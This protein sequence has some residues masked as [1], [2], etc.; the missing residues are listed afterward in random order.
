MR[1]TVFWVTV[2]SSFQPSNRPTERARIGH[3]H[4]EIDR[5][6]P[7]R[8]GRRGRDRGRTAV[9]VDV[10]VAVAGIVGA[11]RR[12]VQSDR[13]GVLNAAEVGIA[14]RRSRD[15]RVARE[16]AQPVADV[17]RSISAVV[18]PPTV[19]IRA[20]SCSEPWMTESRRSGS[21][22]RAC[23]AAARTSPAGSARTRRSSR[24]AAS[25]RS[26]VRVMSRLTGSASARRCC[27]RSRGSARSAAS[28]LEMVDAWLALLAHSS[29]V[30][31]VPKAITQIVHVHALR[32]VAHHLEALHV[33][34]GRVRSRTGWTCR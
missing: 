26:A 22:G 3:R 2:T 32:G 17:A 34:A 14:A 13:L 24:R 30:S 16:I 5:R 10:L 7:R 25:R 4:L 31:A 1:S 20:A 15:R 18:T 28:R 19:A 6:P 23:R 29:L 33:A 27:C 12:G 9:A 8:P 11:D 21:R